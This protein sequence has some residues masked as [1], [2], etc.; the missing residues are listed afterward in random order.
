MATQLERLAGLESQSK[1]YWA[2]LSAVALAGSLWL[3]WLTN[4]LIDVQ[5]K[6]SELRQMVH[7]GGL[8]DIVSQLRNPSSPEHLQASLSTVVAQIQT[9]RANKIRPDEQKLKV[10]SSALSNVVQRVPENP[11]AW[12]AAVQLVD[13]KFQALPAGPIALPNCYD[14]WTGMPS[15]H[16]D[17]IFNQDGTV[18]ERSNNFIPD[19]GATWT[20]HATFHDCSLN[21]DYIDNFETTNIG[22]FFTDVKRHHP[23]ADFLG[24]ILT[25]VHVTYSGGKIIPVSEIQFINCTFEIKKP[26]DVPNK[27][28]QAIAGQLLTAN[29]SGGTIQ[30]PTGM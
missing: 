11:E 6:V 30:L 4:R 3:G 27:E 14:Y 15:D 21:I 8:G 26:T 28:V 25:N 23:G 16:T 7:D 17:T 22:R 1:W 9:A 2:A 5:S 10:L 29:T 13:Y 18:A 24:L 12:Q 19:T 20:V